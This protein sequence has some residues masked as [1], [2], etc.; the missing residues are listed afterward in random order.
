VYLGL[1]RFA[2][3]R[4]AEGQQLSDEMDEAMRIPDLDTQHNPS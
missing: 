2:K 1:A 3:P 4:A